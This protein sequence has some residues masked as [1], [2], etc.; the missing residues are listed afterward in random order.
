MTEMTVAEMSRAIERLETAQRYFVTK[1]VH[2]AVIDALREDIAEIKSDLRWMMRGI[3][4]LFVAG[5]IQ[6]VFLIVR[7][8]LPT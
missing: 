3:I 4:G 8:G 7:G 1:E 2:Q 5:V 6:V